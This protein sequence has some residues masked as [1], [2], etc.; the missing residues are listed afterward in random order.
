MLFGAVLSRFFS[1]LTHKRKRK[2]FEQLGNIVHFSPL[3][4]ARPTS[5]Q[6]FARSGHSPSPKPGMYSPRSSSPLRPPQ[7]RTVSKFAVATKASSFGQTN[8][9]CTLSFIDT[10]ED[11]T[12]GGQL[13]GRGPMLVGDNFLLGRGLFA[14]YLEIFCGNKVSTHH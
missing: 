12:S 1:N 3:P 8:G 7:P 13:L 14:S 5:A 10:I 6:G 4:Q 2:S 9:I 11:W